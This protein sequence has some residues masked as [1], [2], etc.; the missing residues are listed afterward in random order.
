[1]SQGY[2]ERVA[3]RALFRARDARACDLKYLMTG[4]CVLACVKLHCFPLSAGR[5][6]LQIV[7]RQQPHLASAP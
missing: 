7:V 1:M 5:T 3:L 2:A 4:A 6:D